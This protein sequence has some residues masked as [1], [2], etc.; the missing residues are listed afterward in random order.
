MK[1]FL[2]LKKNLKKD[3]SEFP[4]VKVAVLGDSAT[5]FLATALKGQGYEMGLHLD[6]WEA[7]YDQIPLQVHN[8]N[9]EL[10]EF[11]PDIIVLFKSVQKLLYRYQSLEFSESGDFAK[12]EAQD[13][14]DLYAA[15]SSQ[16][17][18]RVI[19]FNYPEVNDS[20]FGNYANKLNFSFLHQLRKLNIGIAELSSSAKDLFVLD[21]ADIQNQLG[22]EAF[23]NAAMYVNN[24][25]VLSLDALPWVAKN[26]VD[27]IN[28][29]RGI[30]KKCIILDLDNT[31][32]GGVIGD[33][34]MDKIQIGDFGIGK[35]FTELQMWVKKLK[36]RGVIV[37]VCSKNT[38][39][40]AREPF[41][42]HPDMVLRE[43]DISVFVANWENK[44]DNIRHIQKVLNIGFDS[45]VFLDD[46][47]FER[48]IV[49]EN[50]PG[51]TVPELPEDPA[52]YLEYLYTLNLFETPSYSS[53][54]KD[55]TQKYQ[56][57]AK[58]IQ[59]QE[60]F[61]DENSFLESLE[62]KA[63]IEGF[64]SFNTPRVSQLT[65][66]SNQFNLRTQRYTEGDIQ[67]MANSPKHIDLA[68]SLED[69]Y[70]DYG[71]ISVLI[72]KEKNMEELF[73]DTWLMSCRVLKRGMEK[74][75]L[76][77]LVEKAKDKGYSKLVGE[78]LQTAK[79]EIV[80][81]HYKDLGFTEGEDG[82]WYLELNS[83]A[84]AKTHIKP[85]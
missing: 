73:I 81:N 56:V 22:R 83:F 43:S 46:N 52:Q 47:P 62:M 38:E 54:D 60:K 53:E 37:A 28:S 42:K 13:V 33:D 69:K 80:R 23:F 41:Q 77:T 68:F 44:A 63:K 29:T 8:P 39:S 58:R 85:V 66:R 10:Y 24:S 15:I 78:Y 20:L 70:G 76:S 61:T 21:L 27:I 31:T 82:L 49:R 4:N 14:E 40:I 57:E 5:Q 25:M 11:E 9:S 34:G 84:P 51:I 17:K 19:V 12:S 6:I 64:T 35:A 2:A 16:T 74:F 72:L 48:N 45:M 30:F 3:F 59:N 50:I 71:L 75:V 7:D 36:E 67:E 26:T 65:Q 79:N 32:W 55:R 18:A 1:N